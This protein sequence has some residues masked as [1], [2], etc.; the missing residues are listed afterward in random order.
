MRT[1][2]RIGGIAA[3]ATIAAGTALPALPALAQGAATVTRTGSCTGTTHWTMKASR[4][5]GRIEVE[6]EIDSNKAGQTWNWRLLHNGSLSAKG[7]STTQAPDGS[8]TVR[9]LVANLSGTDHLAFRAVN[10]KTSEVCRGTL[11][12]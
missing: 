7:S 11:A 9:R 12:F 8:F 5:N 10:P 3:V 4:D 1:L 6:S 2:T